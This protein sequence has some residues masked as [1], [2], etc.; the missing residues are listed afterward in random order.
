MQLRSL[1]VAMISFIG[2]ACWVLF[3]GGLTLI[4]CDGT[5]FEPDGSG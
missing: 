3:G 5:N 4:P 1:F 2:Q